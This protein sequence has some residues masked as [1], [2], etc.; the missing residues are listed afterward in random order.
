MY[1]FDTLKTVCVP[2]IYKESE[3]P[4]RKGEDISQKTPRFQ[5]LKLLQIK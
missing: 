2:K 1:K 5:E 3:T 4:N